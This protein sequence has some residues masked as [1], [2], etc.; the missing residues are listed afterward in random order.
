M[1]KYKVT[2]IIPLYNA[3]KYIKQCIES[4]VRQTLENK[5]I[6]IVNDGSTDSSIEQVQYYLNKYEYIR[7]I[8]QMNEGPSI[9]RNR[10]MKQAKGKYLQF[11]D[12]DDFVNDLNYAMHFYTL[13]E[14]YNLDIIRGQYILVNE[15]LEK[16]RM[17]GA[18]K[19]S[20]Q[21]TVMYSRSYFNKCIENHVYEVVPVLGFYKKSF[22]EKNN[23]SFV[24]NV[25]MEDHEF[26]LKC[27]TKDKDCRLMEISKP[28]YMYRKHTG[29]ITTTYKEKNIKDI[30]TNIKS[31]KEYVE[32]NNFNDELKICCNQAVSAL[33]YQ[34]TSIYGRMKEREKKQVRPLF[35]K[36]IIKYSIDYAYNNHHKA[37]FLVCYYLWPVLDVVYSIKNFLNK[38]I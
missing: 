1:E 8:N 18:L 24:P 20:E 30:L 22:L 35:K 12:A 21:S 9:A 13:C 6:I 16:I 3:E 37:K 14:K 36:E 28:F 2:F 27:L 7:V 23:L 19:P 4:L 38:R 11:I 33:F 10:A 17:S 26:T 15:N 34:A 25:T 31:M 29:S 32:S 5:E